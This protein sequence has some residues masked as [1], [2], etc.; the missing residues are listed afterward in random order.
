MAFDIAAAR[1]DG[2]PDSVIADHLA[3]Q[4]NFDIDAARKDGVPD[5]VIADHLADTSTTSIKAPA[6]DVKP[7]EEK[8]I[9]P[10][11]EATW[12]EQLNPIS[13]IKDIG[14]GLGEGAIGVGKAVAGLD[15]II[16]DP[17]HLEEARAQAAKEYK[18]NEKTWY[19]RLANLA[20]DDPAR[21]E[22]LRSKDRPHLSKEDFAALTEKQNYLRSLESK[23]TQISRENVRRDI[24]GA[25]GFWDTLGTGIKSLA[26]NPR[27]T[28]MEAVESV[29]AMVTGSKIA[30]GIE[31]LGLNLATRLGIG[32][33]VVGAGST[34]ASI[35]EQTDTGNLTATQKAASIISGTLTGLLGAFGQKVS[36]YIGAT[37]VDELFMAGANRELTPEIGSK[38]V[39]AIKSGMVE[40]SVEEL[41]QS[42]QDQ[43]AQNLA[44]GKPWDEGVAEAMAHG[45]VTAFPMGAVAGAYEQGKAN[46]FIAGTAEQKKLLLENEAREKAQAKENKKFDTKGMTAEEKARYKLEQEGKPIPKTAAELEA[47]QYVTGTNQTATGASANLSGQPDTTQSDTGTGATDGSAVDGTGSNARATQTGTVSQSATLSPIEQPLVDAARQAGVQFKAPA[48]ARNWVTKNI[49]KG[50]KEAAAKLEKNNPG[51]YKRLVEQSRATTVEETKQAPELQEAKQAEE[52]KQEEAATPTFTEAELKEQEDLSATEKTPLQEVEAQKE[53]AEKLA[54]ELLPSEEA[55]VATEPV[56]EE[57]VKEEVKE[58]PVDKATAAKNKMADALARLADKATKTGRTNIIPEQDEEWGSILRDLFSATADMGIVKFEDAVQFVKTQLQNAGISLDLFKPEQYMSAHDQATAG[59]RSEA[60]RAKEAQAEEE[61]LQAQAEAPRREAVLDQKEAERVERVYPFPSAPSEI[62]EAEVEGYEANRASLEE[63]LDEEDAEAKL[64]AWSRLNNAEKTL[65]STVN[66]TQGPDAAIK[67]LFDF[68]TN[69]EGNV[70]S[71]KE[72]NAAIYELNRKAASKEHQI[73]FPRWHDLT[74][75]AKANFLFGLPKLNTK[76]PSHSGG[77]LHTAFGSVADQLEKENVAFRGKKQIDIEDAELAS[78]SAQAQEEYQARMAKEREAGKQAVGKG[79]KLP[80]NAV[81]ALETKGVNG[82]LDFIASNGMGLDLKVKKEISGAFNLLRELHEKASQKIFKSLARTL[83]RIDFKSRIVTDPDDLMIMRLQ[84]EGKLAEYDPKTDTFYFTPEGM[85]EATILHEVLHAATVNLISLYK[86]NPA[87]LTQNQRDAVEHLDKLYD[88]VNKR[89]GNKYPNATEN[90]YEFVAYA[91]TDFQF[92]NELAQLQVPRLGKY[93]LREELGNLVKSAWGQFTTALSEMYNLVKATPTGLKLYDEV[94]SGVAK[95]FA[96]VKGSLNELYKEVTDEED[97]FDELELEAVNKRQYEVKEAKA[98]A[99]FMA[100]KR[101]LS[102][103]KGFENNILLEVAEV[104][105]Q[106][107]TAPEVGT[108]VQPLSARRRPTVTKKPQVAQGPQTADQIWNQ[109]VKRIVNKTSTGV[110]QAVKY[111]YGV[112]KSPRHLYRAAVRRFENT[113]QPLKQL[114]K[115][116]QSAKV[117]ITNKSKQFNNVYQLLMGASTKSNMI[118]MQRIAAHEEILREKIFDLK[119]QSGLKVDELFGELQLYLS[120]LHEPERRR[121]FF[122]QD[123]PLRTDSASKVTINGITDTPANH[124]HRLLQAYQYLTD[125]PGGMSATDKAKVIRQHLDSL[126]FSTVGDLNAPTATGRAG[127]LNRSTVDFSLQQ[128]KPYLYDESNDRNNVVGGYSSSKIDI[129]R[130]K[131]EAYKYKQNVY[132]ILNALKRIQDE[133]IKMNLESNFYTQANKNY[134]DMLGN[135]WYVPFKGKPDETK[136]NTEMFMGDNTLNS[137]DLQFWD[138]TAKGRES[139]ADNPIIQTLVDAKKSAY[140]LSHKDVTEATVNCIKQGHITGKLDK[141]I[142]QDEKY[143]M[144]R[145][146]AGRKNTIFRHLDNGKIEVWSIADPVILNAL[147]RPYKISWNAFTKGVG[148]F[149]GALTRTIGQG[150][151]RFNPAFAPA[152]AVKDTIPNLFYITQEY[153]ALAGAEYLTNTINVAT[154]DTVTGG[155]VFSAGIAMKLYSEKQYAKLKEKAKTDNFTKLF[156]ELADE[157]GIVSYLEAVSSPAEYR[158]MTD[159]LKY[160]ELKA[161]QKAATMG[162]DFWLHM[163]EVGVR[164]SVY[165]TVKEHLMDHGVSEKEAISQAAFFAKEVAN[166]EHTG[167]SGKTMATWY[168]FARAT[169]TGVVRY[170]DDLSYAVPGS[171]NPFSKSTALGE[172]IKDLPASIKNDPAAM[173]N[174]KADFKKRQIRARVIASAYIG[175]GYFAYMAAL[176]GSEDDDKDRNIIAND[177]MALWTRAMRFTVP[178]SDY[179]FQV[180]TGY[181][182]GSLIALGQQIAGL[183]QGTQTPREFLSNVATIGQDSFMPFPVSRI[184]ITDH[185]VASIVDTFTPSDFKPII[186]YALLNM[187]GLGTQIVRDLGDNPQAYSS[188]GNVPEIYKDAARWLSDH[189]DHKYDISP[190]TLYFFASNYINGINLL[191]KNLDNA[192]MIAEGDKEYDIS[193]DNPLI[194]SFVGRRPTPD[195]KEYNRIEAEIKERKG[196]LKAA[197]VTTYESINEYRDRYPYD[198]ELVDAYNEDKARLDEL[199]EQRRNIEANTSDYNFKDKKAMLDHNKYAQEDLK[200]NLNT[201]YKD[202]DKTLKTSRDKR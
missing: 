160:R 192:S 19:G 134:I 34:A 29:P 143:K 27:A 97:T 81:E 161:L 185:P 138:P 83:S 140:I 125:T 56:A 5:S 171:L 133:T 144:T 37:D 104:M 184:P 122:V 54:D 117:L 82:V 110:S 1:K 22:Q 49:F 17:S 200:Y 176:A 135:Q 86:S 188:H 61:L 69:K 131:L 93:T 55:E 10:E 71:P 178:G 76:Q 24:E 180:P 30:S 183:N 39:N 116:M 111:V 31:G 182:P 105:N 72:V 137:G 145:Q 92:Q 152:N 67:A 48:H 62:T 164:V 42:A 106:I 128:K 94:Y 32:E 9:G 118:Y 35:A 4:S 132:D 189:S 181:G 169:A 141:V 150:F 23:A 87:M 90:I 7:K 151:T 14:L 177:D 202:I 46:A 114:G 6:V 190:N 191:F 12:G 173:K 109:E 175:M 26:L 89:L 38:L 147:R 168:A 154:A 100:A 197:D 96:T 43:I 165:K 196:R 115:Q 174:F 166:F 156:L 142:T 13:A 198:K 124:R 65:Y 58:A 60:R 126:V 80:E 108:D 28:T 91:M 44:L 64:P 112:V 107:L 84:Q 41:P 16:G 63:D 101:L 50:D 172:A 186:E 159:N 102:A 15:A 199:R 68:R 113:A 79:V 195:S 130:A 163:A 170:F 78:Q 59:L 139:I 146:E 51:I 45:L 75:K 136:T 179:M 53:E 120:G 121:W 155:G 193:T 149:F 20:M 8:P 129:Y 21:V 201:R 119:K 11:R 47:E 52:V 167:I 187:N 157:G 98:P 88:F 18:E 2:V 70:E 66:D 162:F 3:K 40:S 73:Q 148:T 85:D 103:E 57:V 25:E 127:T 36:K 153:G 194:S 158:D 99:K 74:D 33:G 77:A 123:V 95:D